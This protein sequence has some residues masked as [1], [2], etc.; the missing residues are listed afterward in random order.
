[1]SYE[2][3]IE[4]LMSDDSAPAVVEEALECIGA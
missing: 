1:M 4:I 2:T 3:A